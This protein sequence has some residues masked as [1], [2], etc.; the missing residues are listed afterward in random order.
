MRRRISALCFMLRRRRTMSSFYAG[1]LDCRARH[2]RNGC[3]PP[4]SSSSSPSLP[5]A[6][7]WNDVSSASAASLASR[8]MSAAA[9]FGEGGRTQ[10]SKAEGDTGE[11]GIEGGKEG[12]V[13]LWPFESP[14]PLSSSARAFGSRLVWRDWHHFICVTCAGGLVTQSDVTVLYF[15]YVQS[16]TLFCANTLI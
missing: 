2:A 3:S 5:V 13:V 14:R 15:L 4:P 16:S 6:D 9:A 1:S 10:T 8:C 12:G 7:E 11:G